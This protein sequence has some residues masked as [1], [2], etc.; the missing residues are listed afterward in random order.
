MKKLLLLRHAKSSWKD[1]SLID[2]DRPLK[3]RG[4]KDTPEMARRML[5]HQVIPELIISSGAKRALSTSSILLDKL[6]VDSNNFQVDDDLYHISGYSLI[7]YT[8]N[9]PNDYDVILLVSHNPG[10]NDF[11]NRMFSSFTENIPTCGLVGINYNT[12]SW[13]KITKANASLGFFD[14]PKNKPIE[15][16]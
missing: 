12:D 15:Y 9:L 1:M 3:K 16:S 4:I 11:V 6:K 8:R 14:Y 7:E 13:Y 2:Y 10:L 5:K